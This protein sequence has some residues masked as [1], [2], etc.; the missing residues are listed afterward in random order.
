MEAL[1][2]HEKDL[3]TFK[4]GTM[5]FDA[6]RENLE[7]EVRLKKMEMDE[8]REKGKC[9][10]DGGGGNVRGSGVGEMGQQRER[11]HLPGLPRNEQGGDDIPRLRGH[12]D[13]ERR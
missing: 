8:D 2:L 11:Q 5:G 3:P 4:G 1:F 6:K 7:I 10:G 12:P 13:G 9:G